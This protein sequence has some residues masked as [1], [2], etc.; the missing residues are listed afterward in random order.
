VVAGRRAKPDAA[1]LA[2]HLADANA[3]GESLDPLDVPQLDPT[4]V[5]VLSRGLHDL[6]QVRETC[7]TLSAQ[8][9]AVDT[10]VASVFGKT[11]S[12]VGQ[13]AFDTLQSRLGLLLDAYTRLACNADAWIKAEEAMGADLQRNGGGNALLRT[14]DHIMKLLHLKS[15]AAVAPAV[16]KLHGTR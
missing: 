5:G 11:P 2:S 8:L 4:L 7:N 10:M 16:S 1:L 13:S 15:V 3:S 14:V 6:T 12:G 9:E